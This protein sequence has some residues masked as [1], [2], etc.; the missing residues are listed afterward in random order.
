MTTT[1]SR[2]QPRDQRRPWLAW[3]CVGLSLAGPLSGCG[4]SDGAP[5]LSIDTARGLPPIQ[6]RDATGLEPGSKVFVRGVEVAR[7]ESL[8]LEGGRVRVETRLGEGHTPSF[9][10]GACVTVRETSPPSLAVRPGIGPEVE[11]AEFS[12]C[13]S[14]P[15]LETDND[16]ACPND[17]LS[18][19]I[20][21]AT[22]VPASLFLPDGGWRV[23]LTF[24]NAGPDYVEVGSS[25]GVI[26]VADDGATFEHESLPD[27][28]DWHMSFAVG[29]GKPKTVP[30]FLHR[31]GETPPTIVRLK[32]VRYDCRGT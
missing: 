10:A 26:F 3:V 28:R 21:A 6:L 2:P 22:S 19:D 9:A 1:D 30:V 18:V 4:T 27:E 25:S 29:P 20:S 24:S 14:K 13:E 23:E 32:G 16:P 8:K 5:L 11:V 15:T 12:E 17:L 7:V 31:D